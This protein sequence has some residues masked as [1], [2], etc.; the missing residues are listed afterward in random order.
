MSFKDSGKCIPRLYHSHSIA[1][2]PF[3]HVICGEQNSGQRTDR[4]RNPFFVYI[5]SPFLMSLNK[6]VLH[7]FLYRVTDGECQPRHTL[8]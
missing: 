4:L 8:I 3:Y 2:R 6:S 5:T 1:D 7:I